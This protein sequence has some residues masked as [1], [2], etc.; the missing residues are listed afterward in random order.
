MAMF[1]SLGIRCHFFLSPACCCSKNL[2]KNS[3]GWV[4]HVWV[5]VLGVRGLSVFWWC[6]RTSFGDLV[7][8]D[9]LSVVTA[10]FTARCN[11]WRVRIF[12]GLLVIGRIVC[13]DAFK[14]SPVCSMFRL[15]QLQAPGV[16]LPGLG[17]VLHGN[18]HE[19]V[20]SSA[21]PQIC[22]VCINSFFSFWYWSLVSV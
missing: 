13:C 3:S 21:C 6:W 8:A 17:Y 2:T 18:G 12:E 1:V 9:T 16:H 20:C 22:S 10:L 15:L 14:L 5:N 19:C 7:N 11:L 4:H